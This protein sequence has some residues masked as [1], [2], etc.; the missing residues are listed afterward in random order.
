MIKPAAFSRYVIDYDSA[1]QYSPASKF[2]CKPTAQKGVLAD[3]IQLLYS[4]MID[5]ANCDGCH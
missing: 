5:G 3:V 1:N 2:K 4:C